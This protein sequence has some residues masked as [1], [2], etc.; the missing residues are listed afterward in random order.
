MN[1][2]NVTTPRAFGESTT[3]NNTVNRITIHK[4][5]PEVSNNMFEGEVKEQRRTFGSA[6]KEKWNGC[7]SDEHRTSYNRQPNAGSPTNLDS[8][9]RK[10]HLQTECYDVD[11]V[12]FSFLPGGPRTMRQCAAAKERPEGSNQMSPQNLTQF[13]NGTRKTSKEDGIKQRDTLTDDL[14]M[15]LDSTLAYSQTEPS[16]ILKSQPNRLEHCQP[17]QNLVYRDKKQIPQGARPPSPAFITDRSDYKVVLTNKKP[18]VF[19]NKTKCGVGT[20]DPPSENSSPPVKQ[21]KSQRYHLHHSLNQ[22]ID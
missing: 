17:N 13:C 15:K 4:K 6:L 7:L 20:Q 5:S 8:S 1:S 16:F 3:L 19:L 14:C 12:Q 9:D 18:V 22:L 10:L 21:L 11:S 2:S